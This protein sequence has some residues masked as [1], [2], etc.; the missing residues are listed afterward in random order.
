MPMM[1]ENA[2]YL[3]ESDLPPIG[4]PRTSL[5]KAA[6][7]PPTAPNT[8]SGTTREPQQPKTPFSRGESVEVFFRFAK[9][10]QAGGYFPVDSMTQGMLHPCI[11][12]TDGWIPAIV[13]QDWDPS[14]P[15]AAASTQN[16]GDASSKDGG[17]DKGK[18]GQNLVKIKY[19]H[20][21]WY[22]RQGQIYNEGGKRNDSVPAKYV[23]RV[24]DVP[25]SKRRPK[26]SLFCVRWGGKRKVEAVTEGIGGWGQVGSNPSDNFINTLL[27]D[28]PMQQWGPNYEIWS[29]FIQSTHE[30]RDIHPALIKQQMRG[31]YLAGLYFLWPIGFQDGHEFCGY[32]NN[33]D[34]FN[35]MSGMECAGIVSRFPHHSNFYRLLASK[36]WTAPWGLVPGLNTPLTTKLSR[37]LI[38]EKGY[39]NAAQTAIQT[40]QDMNRARTLLF[41]DEYHFQKKEK[42]AKGVAKLGY[43]WESMDVNHWDSVKTLASGLEELVQQ[44]GNLSEF[45]HVQEWV[46]IDVEMRHF[47]VLP[48]GHKSIN[49]EKIV[50]TCY[51]S[52]SENH[53]SSFNRFDRETCLVK[54]FNG[55]E[56]ALAEAER[57]AKE[58]ITRLYYALRAEC[59]E[60]P[61][62]LR[63]D[64]LAHKYAPGKA[65]VMIGEIT[66]LGACF[67]GW[68][69]GP[70][71]VFNALLQSCTGANDRGNWRREASPAA[72][73]K[74][75]GKNNEKGQ[76]NNARQRTSVPKLQNKVLDAPAR[77]RTDSTSQNMNTRQSSPGAAKLDSDR[78]GVATTSSTAST[79]PGGPVATQRTN[80]A[81]KA[82]D[83]T[84]GSPMSVD[85]EEDEEMDPKAK[86]EYV[87][88]FPALGAT[89]TTAQN[90]KRQASNRSPAIPGQAGNNTTTNVKKVY[91]SSVAKL[92]STAGS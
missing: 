82:G 40:L 19:S 3:D 63:F 52:K 70:K 2:Y 47:V 75:Q 58:L 32:V 44:P 91:N 39:L 38:V 41:P 54:K 53:F 12:R 72:A 64:V 35:C 74:G 80:K 66:E 9:D 45:V 92:T 43:S 69:E 61:P 89:T 50:Y 15:V 48:T 31:Q 1:Q 73:N 21:F 7:A 81:N 6:S 57:L 85:E 8:S 55:D 11:V 37:S 29:A 30:L 10:K 65:R 28:F 24:A 86:E 34:L 62:C 25:E 27:G 13:Q 20:P 60:F 4:Q 18:S 46:D 59:A 79:N 23:R 49:I 77:T 16:N 22:N 17:A 67:L 88:N 33:S 5:P 78:S 83:P 36:S 90:N 51:E 76:G 42:I 71:V 68:P 56:A 14:K 87:A 26:V 84:I